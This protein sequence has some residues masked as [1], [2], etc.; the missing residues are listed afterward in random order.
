LAQEALEGVY[1]AVE[2]VGAHPKLGLGRRSRMETLIAILRVVADGS[3]RP[4]RIMYRANVSWRA[5]SH[6]LETLIGKQLLTKVTYDN[7]ANYSL[8]EKG[9]VIL[10]L[11]SNLMDELRG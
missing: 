2:V 7:K 10:N 4:T 11:Y 6:H 3:E 5:L 8:T 9:Y 1:G